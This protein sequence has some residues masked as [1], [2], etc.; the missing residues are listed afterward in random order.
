MHYAYFVNKYMGILQHGPY[1]HVCDFCGCSRCCASVRS[2]RRLIIFVVV[3]TAALTELSTPKI[4]HC[5]TNTHALTTTL[6]LNYLPC[7]RNVVSRLIEFETMYSHVFAIEN[8]KN[9]LLCQ[10]LKNDQPLTAKTVRLERV[11]Q[12]T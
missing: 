3:S 10:K 4:D 8:A 6:M 11:L 12:M 5:V 9:N 7:I 2:N 1:A